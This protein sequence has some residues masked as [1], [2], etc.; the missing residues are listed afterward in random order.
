[1][2]TKYTTEYFTK[3]RKRYDEIEKSYNELEKEL[4]DIANDCQE[5]CLTI[6]GYSN[7]ILYVDMNEE[8]PVTEDTIIFTDIRVPIE[9]LTSGNAKLVANKMKEK[10]EKIENQR[11]IKNKEYKRERRLIEYNKLKAEFEEVE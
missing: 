8:N 10:E 9:A 6:R 4:N 11:E 3:L 1:M 7:S 2:T 5:Y